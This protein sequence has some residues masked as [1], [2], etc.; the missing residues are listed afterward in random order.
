MSMCLNAGVGCVLVLELDCLF[1]ALFCDLC[2]ARSYLRS[3]ARPPRISHASSLG[4]IT[5]KDYFAPA[6][7]ASMCVFFCVL[8]SLSLSLSL[9]LCVS[10]SVCLCVC[11]YVY[12]SVLNVLIHFETSAPLPIVSFIV[13]KSSLILRTRFSMFETL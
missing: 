3:C 7:C 1:L 12:V 8:L 2:G 5:S 4:R 11:V 13:F 6:V 9:C 10:V